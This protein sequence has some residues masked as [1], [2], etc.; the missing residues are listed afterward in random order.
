M[1]PEDMILYTSV[2]ALRHSFRRFTWF[3]DLYFLLQQKIGWD[4]LADKARRCNLERP[5]LYGVRFLRQHLYLELPAPAL[6]WAA[7]F[8]LPAGE[9]YILKQSF[10]DRRKGEWGD[11]LWSFNVPGR[12]QRC[13]FL[14]ATFFLGPAVLLQVFPYLP[15][16]LFPLAYGLRIG[17]LLFRGS[18]QLAGL[19]RRSF[20]LSA[21]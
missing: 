10:R 5:L 18:R 17:Q 6:E 1:C 12:L 9:E 2:H 14:A 3:I 15:R 21:F 8:A 11:L 16:P 4:V 19:V 20:K 7:N 13:W